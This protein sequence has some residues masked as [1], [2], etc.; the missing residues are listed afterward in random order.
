MNQEI[1][2]NEHLLYLANPHIKETERYLFCWSEILYK[3]RAYPLVMVI[4]LSLYDPV[5]SHHE[6]H[7]LSFVP[8]YKL[9]F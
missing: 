9:E 7:Y 8:G 4:E 1:S 5:E 3:L 6:S 2:D